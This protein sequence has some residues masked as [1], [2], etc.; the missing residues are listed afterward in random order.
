MLLE[1]VFDLWLF[2]QM[3]SLNALGAQTSRKIDQLTNLP[4]RVSV[5]RDQEKCFFVK[6]QKGSWLH[7]LSASLFI[8]QEILK[9]PC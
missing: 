6:P 3:S 5:H 2:G 7:I 8:K 9:T 1:R 4:S